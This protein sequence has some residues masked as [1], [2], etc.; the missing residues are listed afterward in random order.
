MK[1]VQINKY[2]FIK[3]G[4]ETVFFN[5]MD[6]L[7]KEG[8]TVIPFSLKNK[9]NFHSPYEKYFVDYPELS[10]SGLWTKF[11]Y[12]PAFLHNRQAAR[13]LDALLTAEK[14]D[15][16]HIH[17]MFNSFSAA[18]LPVLKKRRIPVVMSVHDYRLVCPAYTFIDGDGRF[19]ERCRTKRYYHCI[20]HRCY[21]KDR[22]NSMLL[23]MD[24]YYR[25]YFIRPA[26]Y[27]HQFIFVSNFS[28]S[29]H[30]AFDPSFEAQSTC[31]YN[32]TPVQEKKE[33][34]RGK[35][36][37]FFGRISAEKG[38]ATLM[39][40]MK[41]LPDITLK[42]AGTGPLLKE[43]EGQNLPNVAFLG[44]QRG[45]DL[46]N[47]IRNAMYVVVPSECYENNPLSVIESMMLGT[48]VIGS[49]IGGI[50]ELI[51]NEQ[52]GYVFEVNSPE[53]LQHTLRKAISIPDEAYYAMSD[54]AREFALENFSG[55][56]HY[57]KLM[58]VYDSVRNKALA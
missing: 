22:L 38:I 42:I 23:A 39:Q 34:V 45:E 40:V 18:I 50:P 57:R 36:L 31:L 44:F 47:C 32:F 58:E 7:A 30:I 5:T 19:C 28:R 43:L 55:T 25:A 48:P 56:S 2:F 15:I 54:A 12:A 53:S 41:R 14:P 1:I 20:V 13:K 4:A 52:T 49:G 27:I 26:E 51:Q 29:K 11:K 3:G 35:Y 6:L 9:K 8:H 46:Y 37:L 10:E 33:R 24:N 17:L 21:R 16:A